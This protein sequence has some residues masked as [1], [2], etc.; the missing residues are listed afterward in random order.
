MERKT[1]LVIDDDP[2]IRRLV[3]VYLERLAFKVEEAGTGKAALEKLQRGRPSLVC[4]DLILPDISGYDVCERIRSRPQ[5]KDVPVL[6]MSARAMPGDRAL[7]EEL[8]ASAYLVKPL[9]RRSFSRTVELLIAANQRRP[10]PPDYVE[11]A[12]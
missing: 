1:A 9:D 12:G 10:S 6:V 4:L 2:D 3:R 7:A 11:Q 8:G 5:T